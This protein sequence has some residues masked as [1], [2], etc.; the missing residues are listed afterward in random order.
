MKLLDKFKSWFR[1]KEDRYALKQEYYRQRR[2]ELTK[3]VQTHIP[4]RIPDPSEFVP[5]F[6]YDVDYG[7][8]WLMRRIRNPEDI[9]EANRDFKAGF[10]MRTSEPPPPQ[11]TRQTV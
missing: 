1:K 2:E 4:Y 9:K 11:L 3:Y 10:P 8:G 6:D 5:W 7:D